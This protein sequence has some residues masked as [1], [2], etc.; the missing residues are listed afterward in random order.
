MSLSNGNFRVYLAS[1]F[2]NEKERERMENV[3]RVLRESGY[4][5]Y[6]PYEFKLKDADS[7]PNSVWAEKIYKGDTD[8]ICEADYV[9]AIIDGMNAD[10]GTS[11]E[12]GFAVGM[13]KDVLAVVDTDV[14][15]SLMVINS[16]E[17][18]I[19]YKDLI[20]Y[21]GDLDLSKC[22]KSRVDVKQS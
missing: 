16:V 11:W 18:I 3:L 21:K 19:S 9:V 12:V 14:T 22:W 1:P 10:T 6:A 7:M 5:V 20:S 13:G 4:S 8:E 17:G 2:F 15:Q